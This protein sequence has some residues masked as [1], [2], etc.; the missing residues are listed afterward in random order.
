MLWPSSSTGEQPDPQG[1]VV[2][3][4][5]EALALEVGGEVL[6]AELRRLHL[7]EERAV[8][9]LVVLERP[10]RVAHDPL[11]S[12]VDLARERVLLLLHEAGAQA[13]LVGPGALL[14][15]ERPVDVQVELAL[16]RREG[17]DGLAGQRQLQ[18]PER[19]LRVRGQGAAPPGRVAVRQ[20]VER[21]RQLR[22]ALNVVSEVIR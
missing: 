21:G 15:A 8:V 13:A 5:D 1:L 16:P 3:V 17:Q 12:A 14:D 4:E 6:D 7:Q 22:E 20:P 11:P 19:L 18:R 10:G 2:T 9:P